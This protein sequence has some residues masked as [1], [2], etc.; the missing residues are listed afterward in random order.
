MIP[1]FPKIMAFGHKTV[2]DIIDGEVE[3]TEKL[4][5]SQMA[6]SKIDGTLYVRSKG[7]LIDLNYPDNLFTE[8]VEYVQRIHERLTEGYVYYC[9]YLKKPKHNTLRYNSIPRN[10]LMLFG[11]LKYTDGDFIN[12]YSDLCYHANE[13]GIDVAPLIY[14]GKM[15]EDVL[16]H[17]HIMLDRQSYLGVA[18]IEGVVL[19]N[20]AK[21][22]LLAD[23][24]LPLMSAKFVSEEFKEVHGATWSK[25]HTNKGGLEHL[26]DMYCTEARWIK[27][28]NAL[29]DEGTLSE[30]PKDIGPLIKHIHTDIIDECKDEIKDALWAL[31]KKEI[32][33]HST[34]GFAEF[35][36]ERLVCDAY[37]GK[38]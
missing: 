10:H 19:K 1:A 5:G 32:L 9:E 26:K 29:R 13:I 35:Y 14:K 18:K 27:A 6:F 34:R 3:V 37:E 21:P 11:I 25:D 8:G 28:I 23:R 7:K 36:K 12:D 24:Y 20:Y 4:D 2:R 31:F 15:Q 30:E 17:L 22:Y 33:G 38:E 16:D